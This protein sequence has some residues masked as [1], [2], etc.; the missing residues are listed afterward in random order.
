MTAPPSR[1]DHLKHLAPFTVI[2]LRRYTVK[3]SERQSFARYFET[4]FPEAFQQ[5]GAIVYGQFL[6]R[7]RP[8]TFTWIRGFHDLEARAALNAAFYDG[9]LWKEHSA[10]MNDRLIDHT[11]V[12]LLQ[13][14]SPEREIP[15]LPAVDPVTEEGA[16]T[17]SW[18]RMSSRP[19]QAAWPLSPRRLK[20]PSPAIAEPA[21]ARRASSS[22]WT[23]PTTSHGCRTAP[24]APIS[25]GSVFSGTKPCSRPHSPAGRARRPGALEYRVAARL[26]RADRPR[27]NS[28]L[29]LALATA[30]C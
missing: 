25:P 8:D 14:L 21:L 12:L 13:P 15:V 30:G 5:I 17:A 10:T 16:L 9:P 18:S 26:S 7:D 24:T 28:S 3:Q 11:N 27:P 1:P 2:E 4:F 29:A 22:P 19:A 20:G 6:E 23:C